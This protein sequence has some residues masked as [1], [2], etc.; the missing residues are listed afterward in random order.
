MISRSTLLSFCLTV[1]LQL[2]QVLPESSSTPAISFHPSDR[3]DLSESSSTL[4]SKS[5][6][7]RSSRSAK[8]SRSRT[9]SSQS[10]GDVTDSMRLLRSDRDA[11]QVGGDNQDS[12]REGESFAIES[13]KSSSESSS[14]ETKKDSEEDSSSDSSSSSWEN[15]EDE[16]AFM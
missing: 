9:P 12:E 3:R 14:S 8:L 15:T 1:L 2:H 13:S 10:D 11:L 4:T 7:A 16:Q 5:D 6:V